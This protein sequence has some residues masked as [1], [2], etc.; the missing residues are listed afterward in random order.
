MPEDT[1]PLDATSVLQQSPDALIL[2]DTE[3]VIRFWNA[4]AERIFGHPAAAAVGQNL[5]LIIPESFRDRHWAGYDHALEART[6]KYVDEWLPTRAL[7]ADGEQIYVEL[8]FAIILD[9]AGEVTGVLASA[10][11]ITERFERDRD[12]RRRLRALESA[13]GAEATEAAPPEA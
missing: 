2:A 4:A 11:D 10:R 5:D 3:G 9:S 6:T 8:G 1:T 7:R 13:A 12:M